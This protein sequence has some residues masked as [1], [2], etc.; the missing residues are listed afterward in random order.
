MRRRRRLWLG[1]LGVPAVLGVA[2]ALAGR[3]YVRDK[4]REAVKRCA[5]FGRAVSS[6]VLELARDGLIAFKLRTRTRVDKLSGEIGACLAVQLSLVAVAHGKATRHHR[7][8]HAGDSSDDA[9][10]ETL[11]REITRMREAR[12]ADGLQS[13]VRLDRFILDESRAL[14]RLDMGMV[15][16]TEGLHVEW[17]R[18][19][20][21]EVAWTDA[22]LAMG[23]MG[24]LFCSG[25]CTL[26]KTRDEPQALLE[27]VGFSTRLDVTAVENQG[28]M[29]KHIIQDGDGRLPV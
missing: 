6:S 9:P 14:V 28:Q 24:S 29:L 15:A 23:P 27:C 18:N 1:V 17:R 20:V 4:M 11:P 19:D 21:L 10:L 13:R 2:G 8:S 22:S 7:A 5:A 12:H 3:P 16:R 25:R 26:R